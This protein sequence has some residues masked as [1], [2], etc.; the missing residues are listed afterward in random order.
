MITNDLLSESPLL[1]LVVPV[2]NEAAVIKETLPYIV[3]QVRAGIQSY[4]PQARVLLLAIDDGSRDDTRGVLNELAKSYENIRYVG[5]T[6]NFGKEAA[7]H[8]GV[9]L[10]VDRCKADVVVVMDSDLQHPP[11]LVSTMWERWCK[12]HRVVEAV[13]RN[14]GDE[15]TLR[16]IAASLFY[17]TFSRASG[18][19]LSQDTDFKLL[20]RSVAQ[21][22][23]QMVERARFFRGIVRWLGFESERI[24][25]D[26]AP[27]AGGESA[28]GYLTLVRYAWRNV[29]LFSSAPMRVV[30]M[31]GLT[32]LLVG[33]LL[34]VKALFDKFSGRSLDGFSTVI[35]LVIVFGSLILVGLGVIGSY[36]AQIYDE[37]KQRPYYVLHPDD[38]TLKI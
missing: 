24:E 22:V 29:T 11:Q 27:R 34:G 4:T 17:D 3:E 14:R 8:A 12:G 38:A 6:R 26:V 25:F 31:L 15:S 32:G 33:I 20:D 30:T 19:T 13:K 37:V 36:V 16:R 21:A 1:V 7:I 35:L 5:F 2:F 23:V 9:K 28:W 18:L 10:A